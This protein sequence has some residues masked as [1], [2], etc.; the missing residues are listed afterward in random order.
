MDKQESIKKKISRCEES[1]T[2]E[3]ERQS[4]MLERRGWG[5]GMRHSKIGFSTSKEDKL[6]S[7][8]AQL[9][10]ELAKLQD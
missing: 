1:L 5:Y 2:K 3:R 7:R 4:A 6:K 10:K 9:K 8:L